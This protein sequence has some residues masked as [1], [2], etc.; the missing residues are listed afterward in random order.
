MEEGFLHRLIDV[1]AL[2]SDLLKTSAGRAVNA[3]L[4]TI[5]KALKEHR[6]DKQAAA[7]ILDIALSTPYAKLKKYQL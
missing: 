1:V 6:E 2:A 4:E 5:A 7:R 3:A